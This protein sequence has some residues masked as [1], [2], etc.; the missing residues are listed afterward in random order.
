MARMRFGGERD[1]ARHADAEAAEDTV[2]EGRDRSVG[3]QE[4]VGRHPHRGSL[5]TVHG[6]DRAIRR[7]AHQKAATAD[8]A[9]LRFDHGEGEHGGDRGVGGAAAAFQHRHACGFGAR[10][11]GAHAADEG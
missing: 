9:A 5:A 2:H 3:V 8:P 1:I 4:P 11:G 7:A 10:I 6:L